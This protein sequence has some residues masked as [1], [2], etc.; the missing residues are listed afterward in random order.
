[1]LLI[2]AKPHRRYLQPEMPKAIVGPKGMLVDKPAFNVA[3]GECVSLNGII[4]LFLVGSTHG[5]REISLNSIAGYLACVLIDQL[6]GQARRA[7]HVRQGKGYV[8][9]PLRYGA[10]EN[11]FPSASP[12]RLGW[13]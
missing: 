4:S 8:S 10:I 13:K 1:M 3:S 12:S 5:N 11:G 7:V 9:L 6:Y 2:W